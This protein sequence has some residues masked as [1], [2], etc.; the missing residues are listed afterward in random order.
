MKSTV[1][2]F[3]GI[4]HINERKCLRHRRI[5][6][7]QPIARY[8][9]HFSGIMHTI[10]KKCLK[11]QQFPQTSVIIYIQSGWAVTI[12]SLQIHV[13]RALFHPAMYII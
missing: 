3:I 4:L 10:F 12:I 8:L 7:F 13:K 2:V 6:D 9:E 5:V 1:P 11:I